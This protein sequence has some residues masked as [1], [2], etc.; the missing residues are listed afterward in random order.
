[1]K[2]VNQRS[3]ELKVIYGPAL[4]VDAVLF[5]IDKDELK[6]LL[7]KINSGPYKNKWA[8]PGGLA[9][10][11]E[12]LDETAKRVLFQKTNIDNVH[13]EQLYSFSDLKRDVRGRVVSVAYFALVNNPYNFKIKT[14]S[15]YSEISWW[16][17][18]NLPP[19]AFDH[20]KI[21]NYAFE[22]LKSKIEYTNIVYSLL[23]EEF[24]LTELQNVYEIILDK[25]LDKR[26]FRKKMTSLDLI[27]K[28][29]NK[30]KGE[31]HRPAEL[32]CF[33]RRKLVFL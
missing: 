18:K 12:T 9:Q 29:G 5:T 32:F 27:K 11:K 17:V 2:L 4:A 25:K 13:L 1:M 22:R 23:P 33:N 28:T 26:N 15:Y 19:M 14:T 10:T 24:T 8:F 6:I 20:Q 30:R 16:S 7:I 31:V 21:V 3:T